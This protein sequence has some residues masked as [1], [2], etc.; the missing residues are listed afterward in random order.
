MLTVSL[1]CPRTKTLF[2]LSNQWP[3]WL[4]F[5]IHMYFFFFYHLSFFSTSLLLLWRRPTLLLYQPSL[6]PP[7]VYLR[8]QALDSPLV[9]SQLW[10]WDFHIKFLLSYILIIKLTAVIHT[11]LCLP[12]S[13]FF[14]SFQGIPSS[15]V[16]SAGSLR[17]NP[18]GLT[19]PPSGSVH[20][21][22]T[23]TTT[24]TP[25]QLETVRGLVRSLW[26]ITNQFFVFWQPKNCLATRK[27][28]SRA[29]PILCWS[30]LLVHLLQCFLEIWG[31]H[32]IVIRQWSFNMVTCYVFNFMFCQSELK[33]DQSAG[34]GMSAIVVVLKVLCFYFLFYNDWQPA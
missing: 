28:G 12:L 10:W 16:S 13:L 27:T 30:I 8:D 15:K 11:L 9:I 22:V 2:V 33:C 4:M 5:Y 24:H 34:N 29:A 14:S 19:S 25:F 7:P 21:R 32:Y 17:S 3:P 20:T 1:L 26:L 18:S 31:S 23:H 6:Q